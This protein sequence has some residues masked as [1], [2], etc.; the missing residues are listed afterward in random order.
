MPDGNRL[1]YERLKEDKLYTKSYAEFVRQFAT[2]EAQAKLHR[3]MSY[4]KVYTKPMGEFSQK[5]FPPIDYKKQNQTPSYKYQGTRNYGVQDRQTLL[6]N[7]ELEKKFDATY[8]DKNLWTKYA[9]I[10][11]DEYL[12]DIITTNENAVDPYVLAGTISAEGMVD[13][14]HAARMA[15]DPTT[16]ADYRPSKEFSNSPDPVMDSI[17]GMRWFGTDTFADRHEEFKKK[18]LTTL[19]PLPEYD[20]DTGK[21]KG[22]YDSTKVDRYFAKS[23]TAINE[24]G[25]EVNP[26]DFFTPKAGVNAV[27]AYLKN[28]QNIVEGSGVKATTEEKEFLI[29]VGYNHGEGGLSAYLKK[30]KT[31][32][33]I[34]EKIKEEKPAVYKNIQ[35]RI[36]VSNELRQSKAFEPIRNSQ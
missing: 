13:E 10:N 21:Y 34:V 3:V 8:Q 24:K 2:P 25:E 11:S 5:F 9:Y 14:L 19:E 6:E 1:L 31:G 36:I 4:D 12:K 22:V 35:K 15:G 30:Y 23:P 28:I 20:R 16:L 7:M 18:G 29:H 32:R 26:A 27:S 33:E 17:A